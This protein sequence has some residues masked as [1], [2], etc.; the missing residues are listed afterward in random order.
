MEGQLSKWTNLMKGW[1]YRW[2]T[3]DPDSGML[4]YYVVRNTFS[5]TLGNFADVNISPEKCITL[6]HLVSK[7]VP[8]FS[9]CLMVFARLL[10]G[11]IQK[12]KA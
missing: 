3:L 2:F 10:N 4:D 6:Y 7:N 5:T 8:K 1:Q 11:A 9:E 12:L